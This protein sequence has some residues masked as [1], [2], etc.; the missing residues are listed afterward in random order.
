M[1]PL[2]FAVAIAVLCLLGVVFLEF[3]NTEEVVKIALRP[4]AAPNVALRSMFLFEK[5][6]GRIF[7]KRT[8]TTK[9]DK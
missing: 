2:F 8:T 1:L 4:C 7:D 6:S 9:I 3:G 5:K